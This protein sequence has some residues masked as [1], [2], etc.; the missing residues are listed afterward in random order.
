MTRPIKLARSMLAAGVAAARAGMHPDAVA[1]DLMAA[2]DKRPRFDAPQEA[3]EDLVTASARQGGQPVPP[4]KIRAAIREATSPDDLLERLALVFDALPPGPYAEAM[5]RALFAA[6]VMG[7]AHAPGLAR[8]AV[9][10]G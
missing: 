10:D 9:S 4:E 7:Y 3:V 2:A 6:D 8:G 1:R 5:E